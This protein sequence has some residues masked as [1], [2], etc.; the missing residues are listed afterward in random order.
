MDK[1]TVWYCFDAKKMKYVFNHIENEWVKS[2]YPLPKNPDFI[3]QKRWKMSQW[4]KVYGELKNNKVVASE[5][6]IK[7]INFKLFFKNY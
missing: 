6:K 3:L 7:L 1:I 5:I 2:N 4:K